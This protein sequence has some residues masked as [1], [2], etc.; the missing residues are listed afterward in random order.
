MIKISWL[1]IIII[2]LLVSVLIFQIHSCS[3]DKT[4]TKQEL[5]DAFNNYKSDID[6]I[7]QNITNLGLKIDSTQ[8]FIFKLKEDNKKIINETKNQI[9]RMNEIFRTNADTL[10]VN[11]ILRFYT[12]RFYT[13]LPGFFQFSPNDTGI[14]ADSENNATGRELVPSGTEW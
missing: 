11:R 4:I 5:E 3:E 14:T 1:G 2:L 13:R 9:G 8:T 7:N 6:S 12:N 10:F